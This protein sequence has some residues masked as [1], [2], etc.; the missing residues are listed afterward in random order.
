MYIFSLNNRKKNLGKKNETELIINI[1]LVESEK[2]ASVSHTVGG[3]KQKH[4]FIPLMNL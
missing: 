1:P 2:K 3:M 4:V